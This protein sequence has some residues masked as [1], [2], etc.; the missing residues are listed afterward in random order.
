MGE[1]TPPDFGGDGQRGRADT[2]VVEK[3][4]GVHVDLAVDLI[5]NLGENCY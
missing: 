4:R 1:D 3:E 5:L 2:T